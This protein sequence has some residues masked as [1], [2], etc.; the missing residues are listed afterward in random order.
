MRCV[1]RCGTELRSG[2]VFEEHEPEVLPTPEVPVR[3]G[4]LAVDRAGGVVA[5]AGLWGANPA[6]APRVGLEAWVGA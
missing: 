5:A 6:P 3:A 2:L 4:S 1:E